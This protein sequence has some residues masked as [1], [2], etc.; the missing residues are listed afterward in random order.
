MPRDQAA[1]VR[2]LLEMLVPFAS[3]G[4]ARGL[5]HE[6]SDQGYDWAKLSARLHD[7]RDELSARS[8]IH[9]AAD[10]DIAVAPTVKKRWL[11]LGAATIGMIVVAWLGALS[12]GPTR[13]EPLAKPLA[14]ELV[15]I[16]AGPFVYQKGLE[17]KTDVFWIS[18][19]EVT[20]AQYAEFLE[21]LKTTLPANKYDD[22]RQPK[23]KANHLPDDWEAYYKAASTGG[24]FNN[25]PV[26]LN[27]PVCAVDYWDAV[28]YAKWKG[29]RLPSELEWEKA[30]RG[31][32]G[33]PYPWGH[34]ANPKGANLGDD[35]APRALG[36]LTD[37]YNYWAPV[38]K[39]ESDVSAFGIVGMAGNIQEWT[40]T[41]AP[42][43][44][45]VD[46]RV[47]VVRGGYFG[48]KSSDHVLTDRIFAADA[49]ESALARGFRT[50][51]DTEPK[52]K[53]EK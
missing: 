37:G 35:Y 48:L 47:P 9:R 15:A 24:M 17:E 19:Y 43:P 44:D 11:F 20:I 46:T 8:L 13:S 4:K 30:A 50:V 21:V 14:E 6:L 34:N 3:Q 10:E 7:I 32:K 5:L 18:K 26:S 38:N 1:D 33:N 23:T 51:S 29:R 49:N 52:R 41:W 2:A 45:L 31:L 25:H 12:G 53:D 28:A 16:P 27:L 42:H 40:S 39:P 36:G 22:P